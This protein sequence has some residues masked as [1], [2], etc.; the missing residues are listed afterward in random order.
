MT[1][2]PWPTPNWPEGVPQEIA[3]YDIPLFNLID[4]AAQNYPNQTYTIFN[5]APRTFAQVKE[6][7]DRIA[8]FLHAKGIRKGD[9]VAIFLHN[10]PHYPAIY[11]GILKAGAVCVTCNP[12]YTPT[13]LNYQLK[14]AGARALFCM[15]HPGF[16]PTTVEAV[17]A[18]GGGAEDL[19][20]SWAAVEAS[21]V[22]VELG[23]LP[24]ETAPSDIAEAARAAVTAVFFPEG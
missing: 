19:A 10:L 3:D 9:R 2:A 1:L 16:Y 8:N 12:L 17:R 24:G 18:A 7:A 13:E 6:T 20:R 15:D 14:D 5:D 22:G 23:S 21:G 4:E 11:F